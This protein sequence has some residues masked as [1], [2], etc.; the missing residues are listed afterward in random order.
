MNKENL[1]AKENFGKLSL[2]PYPGRGIVMGLDDRGDNVVQIYWIMG[3]SDNSRNR[4]FELVDGAIRTAPADPAKV[5]DPSLI[6]YTAMRE[7]N[8]EVCGLNSGHIVS[9]GAQTDGA[10]DCLS[11][12]K[13]ISLDKALDTWT[14]EPD[15]P[16]FTPRITAFYRSQADYELFE[17]VVIRKSDGDEELSRDVLAFAY[18]RGLGFDEVDCGK[19]YCITTYMGDGN[20][21]P[22]FRGEPLVMPLE[23]DIDSIADAY[24]LALNEANRISLAV[25]FIPLDGGEPTF[26]IIN[27]YEKVP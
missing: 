2:N 13:L 4:V 22:P 3:R 26:K 11:I 1:L 25:K 14:C 7:V 18:E 20:P 8:A 24:W 12:A 23:G 27:K 15:A 19:G 10:A 6:I 9:N 16:N 17:F 21:L 5:K